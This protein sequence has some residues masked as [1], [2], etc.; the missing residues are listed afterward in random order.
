MAKRVTR[1]Y[2][3]TDKYAPPTISNLAGGGNGHNTQRTQIVSNANQI[4]AAIQ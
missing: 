3:S 4:A 2:Q 1:R